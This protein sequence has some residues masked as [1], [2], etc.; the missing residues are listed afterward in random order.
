MRL[1]R[2]NFWHEWDCKNGKWQKQNVLWQNPEPIS[3]TTSCTVSCFKILSVHLVLG[4]SGL[5]VIQ[6]CPCRT[7]GWSL[8][9]CWFGSSFPRK[10]A[11]APRSP[12]TWLAACR[13][14][15]SGR[16]RRWLVSEVESCIG[17]KR[18]I[19]KTCAAQMKCQ[20]ML[21]PPGF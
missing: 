5:C 15:W 16:W 11:A 2:R 12:G 7:F 10:R 17:D 20:E 8:L 1:I 18:H 3:R 19:R 13:S 6:S 21:H 4:S 14:A 9:L